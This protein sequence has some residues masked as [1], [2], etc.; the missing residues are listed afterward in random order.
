MTAKEPLYQFC[1]TN[2]LTH[3][4]KNVIMALNEK[5]GSITVEACL[6]ACGNCR[7]SAFCLVNKNEIEFTSLA[8]LESKLEQ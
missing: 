8:D 4:T 2:M 5:A 1:A 6:K 7:K 3:N